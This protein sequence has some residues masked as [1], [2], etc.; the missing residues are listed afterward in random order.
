MKRAILP[1]RPLRLRF[2]SQ[3]SYWIGALVCL[4]VAAG[5]ALGARWFAS[6]G[7]E[8]RRDQRIW[9]RGIPAA[10]GSIDGKRRSR[11]GL[12]WFIAS[13][14]AHVTYTD[15]R[16]DR[17]QGELDFWTMFGGPDTDAAELR[18]DPE[19]RDQFAVSWGVDASGARWR[20]VVFMTVLFG[21]LALAFVYV[22]WFAVRAMRGERR[23]AASGDE[24]ELR[25]ISRAPVMKQVGPGEGAAQRLVPESTGKWQ[26]ELELDRD[27]REP[28][29]M[30]L[31]LAWPLY[32]APDNARILALADA[33]RDRL[34]ILQ[35]DG[36]PLALS[37]EDRLEVMRRGE[38]ARDRG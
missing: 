25:V 3:L 34:I 10:D 27:G 31:Q 7:G 13:Y 30:T 24:V 16:G 33:S 9:E 28:R 5:L 6:D 19:H 38:A 37:P 22:A 32:C 8:I 35:H 14:E 36:A 2:G 15:D 4:A 11:F 18:H 17:H 20:A 21:L 12:S 1:A 26:F 23:I 29:R